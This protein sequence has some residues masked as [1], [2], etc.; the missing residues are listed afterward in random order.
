MGLGAVSQHLL[1]AN[2]T[3]ESI[4]KNPAFGPNTADREPHKQSPKN[5]YGSAEGCS[6][7]TLPAANAHF[8]LNP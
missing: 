8:P 4:S 1:E 2:G 6:S 7:K 5:M 3:G